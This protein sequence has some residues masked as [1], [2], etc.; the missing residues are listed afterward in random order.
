MSRKEIWELFMFNM[1]IKMNIKMTNYIG[2]GQGKATP[3][4]SFSETE[5]RF[6]SN[7][8]ATRTK[9]CLGLSNILN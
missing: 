6:I 1:K 3:T 9:E 8:S 4:L 2:W 7:M 5:K